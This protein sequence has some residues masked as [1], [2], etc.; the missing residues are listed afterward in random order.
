[1]SLKDAGLVKI[2]LNYPGDRGGL[3]T[4]VSLLSAEKLAELLAWLDREAEDG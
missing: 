3:R 4:R 2:C 1:M